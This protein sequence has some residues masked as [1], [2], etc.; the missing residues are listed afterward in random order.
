MLKN[1]YFL[2]KIGADTAENERNFA[3]NW[4]LPYGQWVLGQRVLTEF[5]GPGARITE[6]RGA[7]RGAAP[8][9]GA[10]RP[11]RRR[12]LRALGPRLP[13]RG[14]PVLRAATAQSAATK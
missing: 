8:G 12:L 9:A 7:R 5:G 1:A 13:C 3:K 11:R 6:H 2:A 4:Q 10:G 14:P